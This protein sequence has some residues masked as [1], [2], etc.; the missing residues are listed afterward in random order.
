MASI[1]IAP[2][3]LDAVQRTIDG[4]MA[5]SIAAAERATQVFHKAVQE[6]ARSD[7]QWTSMADN[8]EIWSQDG[9]LVIG[10][11]DEE[12]IS[13]AELAEYG[14]AGYSPNPLFRKLDNAVENVNRSMQHS[15]D[16]RYGTAMS[17]APKIPGMT[18]GRS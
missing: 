15:F 14:G 16:A 2:G 18:Y 17:T 11:R 1:E 6:I 4:L 5:D 3:W 10:V 7:E 12:F 8:I 9:K 13:Q